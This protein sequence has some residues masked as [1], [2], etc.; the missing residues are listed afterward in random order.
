VIKYVSIAADHYL[1]L[2]L[3]IKDVVFAGMKILIFTGHRSFT[4]YKGEIKE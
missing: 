4:I 2:V 3:M 1:E